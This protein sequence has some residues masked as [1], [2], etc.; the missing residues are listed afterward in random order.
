[1]WIFDKKDLP[2]DKKDPGAKCFINPKESYML[3][4]NKKLNTLEMKLAAVEQEKELLKK[5]VNRLST[6]VNTLS[7]T[8]QLIQNL[9]SSLQKLIVGVSKPTKLNLRKKSPIEI[10]IE[11]V[12]PMLTDLAEITKNITLYE[13]DLFCD[14]TMDTYRYRPS[15]DY[16]A[17]FYNDIG[18]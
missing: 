8:R 17:K 9:T 12:E 14:I 5:K 1:M 3:E 2:S 18:K 16:K 6:S 10:M 7:K 11:E 13:G 4:Y 15:M